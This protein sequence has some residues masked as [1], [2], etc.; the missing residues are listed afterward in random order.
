MIS[1]ITAFILFLFI[2]QA[3]FALPTAKVTI[4]VIDQSGAPVE[5]VQVKVFFKLKGYRS[6]TDRG[7]TDE[8]GE[9]VASASTTQHVGGCMVQKEGYYDGFC[10]DYNERIFTGIS[11]IKGFRRWQP[12]NPTITVVMKKIKNPI[13]LYMR[14]IRQSD[15]NGNLTLVMPSKQ[16]GFDLLVSDWVA[17]YGS[18]LQ[19][20]IMFSIESSYFSRKNFRHVLTVRFPGEGNGIQLHHVGDENSSVFR[21]PYHSPVDGFINELKQVY[22]KN[23][24]KAYKS[25]F[26]DNRYFFFRIRSEYDKKGELS[27]ALYG[28]IE[29]DISFGGTTI[30]ETAWLMFKYYLNPIQNDTNLEFD[31]EKNLFGDKFIRKE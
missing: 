18:G 22:E 11:G 15:R 4:K 27:S 10:R 2:S 6:N 17:P 28:K 20:D 1:R 19:A 7:L 29:G 5:D 3:S 23:P 31:P 30:L 24:R 16:A 26:D 13:A 8:N 12:W 21:L 9:F 14:N 25:P